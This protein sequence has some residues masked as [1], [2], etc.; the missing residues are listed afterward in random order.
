M[1]KMKIKRN[2]KPKWYTSHT[3]N[4]QPPQWW[5]S[6][7]FIAQGGKAVYKSETKISPFIQWGY[8]P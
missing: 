3:Q 7:P 5:A 6:S 2:P 1:K 4:R 8:L